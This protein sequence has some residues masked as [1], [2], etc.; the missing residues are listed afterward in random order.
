MSDAPVDVLIVETE[1]FRDSIKTL[2]KELRA[3]SL[4]AAVT[5]LTADP[6]ALSRKFEPSNPERTFVHRFHV[7]FAFT[8][9]IALDKENTG[10]IT[11]MR[12]ILKVAFRYRGM[13]PI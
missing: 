12:I 9:Q 2:R 4:A 7:R 8:Y 13:S 1:V 3:D 5:K 6:G 11:G 10:D